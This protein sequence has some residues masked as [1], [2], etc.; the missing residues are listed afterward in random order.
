MKSPTIRLVAGLAF[1]LLVIGG[2]A[3][4][5]L[6][7]VRRMREVQTSIVDRNRMGSLQLIRIQNELNALGLSLRDMLDESD[8][9]ALD[10][11]GPPLKRVRENLDD[12]IAREARLSAGIRAPRQTA[13][14]SAS[15]A[16]FWRASDTALERARLGEKRQA[17]ELVRHTLQ[18]R[19]EALSALTARLLVGNND[20]ESRAAGQV[21]VLYAEI[22]R[23]AYVLLGLSL[24]LI[25][26]TSAGLIRSNRQLFSQ[27]STLAEQRRELARQLISTQESTF[28]AI[29][30]DLHDEFG[31]ILTA[32]GAMLRRAQAQ[33]PDS[34][35]REQTQE[36]SVVVQATLEKIRSLSQALQ[37]VILEEQGLVPAIAWHVGEFE[38]H[39]GIAVRYADPGRDVVMAPLQAIHV[40][41]VLQ[42]GL[43]N[44]ARHAEVMEVAV[45][46]EARDGGLELT[47]ADDGRGM[48]GGKRDGVGLAGMRER[49]GLLGGSLTVAPVDAAGKGTRVVL[50]VPLR[51]TPAASLPEERHGAQL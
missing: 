30:R 50:R 3:F 20:E 11:W 24:A 42:E 14:L 31:Q 4:F 34:A 28:R 46:L 37:P 41:R 32:L 33:A 15:L 25:A 10:A 1:T 47:I 43:N 49:A 29:S 51:E 8:R 7:S 5:T 38:R 16:D 26:L 36:A 2:Y 22:E 9:Y 35:F 6:R 21:R 19:L 27:L 17:L 12:A 40:Y 48:A 18:P 39:T 13:Y 23:N 44:V 45:R